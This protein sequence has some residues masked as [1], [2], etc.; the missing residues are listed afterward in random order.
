MQSKTPTLR[1]KD[2]KPSQYFDPSKKTLVLPISSEIPGYSSFKEFK[3]IFIE[4]IIA[5]DTY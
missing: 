2:Y 3:D 4:S 1:I 5:C